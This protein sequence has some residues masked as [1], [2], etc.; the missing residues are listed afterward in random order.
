MP[1]PLEG[2]PS[3][4]LKIDKTGRLKPKIPVNSFM[5]VVFG[6]AKLICAFKNAT[7]RKCSRN[8]LKLNGLV[9]G[10]SPVSTNDAKS[11]CA[12]TVANPDCI[13]CHTQRYAMILPNSAI[14]TLVGDRVGSDKLIEVCGCHMNEYRNKL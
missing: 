2:K 7:T 5:P 14:V 10:I 9:N 8:R 11:P 13:L 3:T 6:D 4:A 1:L 12:L